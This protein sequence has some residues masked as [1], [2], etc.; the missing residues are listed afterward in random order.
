MSRKIFVQV[1]VFTIFL[2]ALLAIPASALA[3]GYCDS[4]YVVQ[5]GD[6]LSSI[7][8]RCG[9]T[10]SAIYAANPGISGYLYAGQLL[11][12]PGYS[13]CGNCP[14]TNYG[15]TYVVRYGDSFAKIANRFGVSIYDLWAANPY[16]WD[17][18]VIYVGQVLS[19]PSS[20]WY[21]H[22]HD[23]SWFDIV[24][25]YEETPEHLSYGTYPD[26]KKVKVRL[27]NKA[28]AD[29]YVSLQGTTK[30][31]FEAIN[32]YTVDGTVNATVP[33]GWYTYVAW[34]GG[35]QY[36]GQFSL[37]GSRTMTFYT[38]GKIVVE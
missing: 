14:P 35:V 30:D 3:G 18:N 4:T 37:N 7:A 8:Q 5:W 25:P 15:N 2:L 33:S 6:T 36:S 34:V 11:I 13:S 24:D 26:N 12:M 38:G 16:I 27:V 20:S 9:T 22:D 17:I 29:V 19:V 21:D 28:H 31:G 23:H 1:S 32:E 10:V